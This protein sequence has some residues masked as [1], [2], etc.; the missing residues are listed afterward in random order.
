L[1][2]RMARFQPSRSNSKTAQRAQA[3]RGDL[4]EGLSEAAIQATKGNWFES[5]SRIFK[6][7]DGSARDKKIA[8][9]LISPQHRGEILKQIGE[10]RNSKKT[11]VGIHSLVSAIQ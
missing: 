1:L 7:G 3:D 10:S 2:R 8:E 11:A 9:L 5:L 4:E 6:S